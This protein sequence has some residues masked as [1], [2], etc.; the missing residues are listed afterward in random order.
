MPVNVPTLE[1]VDVARALNQ[2]QNVNASHGHFNEV[3]DNGQQV[4]FITTI[5]NVGQHNTQE[6]RELAEWVSP[7]N[8]PQKQSNV[9]ETRQKGTGSWVLDDERFKEWKSGDVKTLW[10]PGI[11]GA[12]KTVLAS[13]IIDHL[14]QQHKRD[15]D[16]VAVV[17]FYCN[18]KDQS[19]QTTYNLVASLL[20]Q[21]VQDFPHTFERVNTE[22]RSHREKQ[23]RP[24]LS[25]V[26]NT[27]KKEFSEFS[28]VFIVVDAL[29]EVSEDDSRAELLT[30]L[31]LFVATNVWISVHVM[32]TY[33]NIS[34][35]VFVQG[36]TLHSWA[37]SWINIPMLNK[38]FWSVFQKKRRE[39]EWF[40]FLLCRL[41]LDSLSRKI[42]PRGVL[43]ALSHLPKGIDDA[44]NE[45]IKRIGQLDE[46]RRL[47]ALKIIML[48]AN[49]FV[50]LQTRQLREAIAFS[51]DLSEISNDDLVDE[52]TI[53]DICAGLVIIDTALTYPRYGSL[54]RFVHHTAQEHFEKY[55]GW[56]CA[57]PHAEITR[58][59]LGVLSLPR[60]DG[61]YDMGFE[62]Y[63]RK[64]LGNHARGPVEETDQAMIQ[65][66]YDKELAQ[67][68]LVRSASVNFDVSCKDCTPLYVAAWYS[69][70]KS[71]NLLLACAEIDANGIP[72]WS[73]IPPLWAA[74]ERAFFR[75]NQIEIIGFY[76]NEDSSMVGTDGDNQQVASLLA[77][78]KNI[79]LDSNSGDTALYCVSIPVNDNEEELVQCTSA[80]TGEAVPEP[81]LAQDGTALDPPDDKGSTPL[82]LAHRMET[83]PP[84]ASSGPIHDEPIY[85]ASLSQSLVRK[86]G[87][88]RG[89]KERVAWKTINGCAYER[90]SF[91]LRSRLGF[92]RFP[93]QCTSLGL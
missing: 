3:H 78:Q 12:G 72:E 58:M 5:N 91:E 54:F 8:F 82:E 79:A 1:R 9:S 22:Y 42:T 14:T 31:Q 7:L 36:A 10:C 61:M 49:A 2:A 17:Y 57:N 11:P 19:T 86:R 93:I 92:Y 90:Q 33:A 60:G 4:N 81:P 64:Y 46:E 30:S 74:A 38:K 25:E 26:C 20:K 16:N 87:I 23:I 50:P 48:I 67:L 55:E 70:E 69:D 88:R 53:I 44:Y 13:Y 63:A 73:S 43:D 34:K 24:T 71:V 52:T 41:H 40:R 77:R 75:H 66:P 28:R 27:L 45:T 62:I 89:A 83:L 6:R 51:S 56:P 59:C 15:N 29:D 39:Y 80:D 32:T 21:L 35:A 37:D 47:L 68:F 65:A 76:I 85:H 18:H 84:P